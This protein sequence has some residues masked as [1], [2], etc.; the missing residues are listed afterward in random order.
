MHAFDIHKILLKNFLCNFTHLYSHNQ[1]SPFSWQVCHHHLLHSVVVTYFVG[2]VVVLVVVLC[3]SSSYLFLEYLLSKEF[4]RRLWRVWVSLQTR[5]GGKERK[6]KGKGRVTG[7][8]WQ[9]ICCFWF[10]GLL[11]FYHGKG[12]KWFLLLLHS[13]SPPPQCQAL[14]VVIGFLGGKI[15]CCG[16]RVFFFLWFSFFVIIGNAQEVDH[17]VQGV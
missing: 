16:V 3:S 12:A 17:G 11:S 5:K 7:K 8:N 15:L 10:C 4:T 1:N 9:Q 6:G 14:F 2:V 13:L